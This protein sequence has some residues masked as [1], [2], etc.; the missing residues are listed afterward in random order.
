MESERKPSEEDLIPVSDAFAKAI[1]QI[2]GLSPRPEGAKFSAVSVGG[3]EY[4]GTNK[5]VKQ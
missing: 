5:E 1:S 3:W 2:Y 4:H